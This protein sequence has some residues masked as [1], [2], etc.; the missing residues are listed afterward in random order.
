MTGER[1]CFRGKG[2]DEEKVINLKLSQ[3]HNVLR[4]SIRDFVEKEIKP[5]AAKIDGD[6]MIPDELVR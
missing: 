4:D 2:F 1:N 5:I 6:Q 3:N